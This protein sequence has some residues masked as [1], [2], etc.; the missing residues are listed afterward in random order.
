MPNRIPN[1]EMVTST[2]RSQMTV[3]LVYFIWQSQITDDCGTCC[4]LFGTLPTI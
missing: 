1:P 3:N 4:I 2:P